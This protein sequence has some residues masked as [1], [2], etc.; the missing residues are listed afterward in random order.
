MSHTP[1]MLDYLSF[2]GWFD[3]NYPQLNAKYWKNITMPR[4]DEGVNLTGTDI[5]TKDFD[6][7]VQIQFYYYHPLV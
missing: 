2:M 3:K 4:D 6:K 1:Q 7:L 5:D